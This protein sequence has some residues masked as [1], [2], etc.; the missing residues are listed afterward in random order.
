MLIV[1]HVLIAAFRSSNVATIY[2]DCP[3][4]RERFVASYW[5][6]QLLV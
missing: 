5:F 4:N 1:R 2:I 3:H 6:L